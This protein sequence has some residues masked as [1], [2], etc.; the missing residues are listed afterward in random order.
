MTHELDAKL[1]RQRE[2]LSAAMKAKDQKLRIVKE[3]IDSE[4]PPVELPLFE[5]EPA[6]TLKSQGSQVTQTPKSTSNIYQNRRNITASST[7][8]RTR[9]SRSVGK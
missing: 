5:S 2:H 6:Y 7:N 3:I 9:R 8:H 1:R 4:M